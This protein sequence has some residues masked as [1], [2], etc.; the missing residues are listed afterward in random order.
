MQSVGSIFSTVS[1]FYYELNPATLSGAIDVVVVEQADGELSCSPFH[2]RFGKLS[3]LRPQEKVVEV[4]ING[5]VVDFPMKVGDAGEAFFVFETEQEVPE[6]FATSPLAGPSTDKVEEDIVYLDLAQGNNSTTHPPDDAALDTGYVSAHSGHGSEFEEDERADLSPEL[7]KNTHYASVVKFGGAK[8]QSRPQSTFNKAATPVHAFMEERVQRWSLTMSLPPSPVL[9]ARDIMENFQPIDSAGPF[10]DGRENT[11]HLLAPKLISSNMRGHRGSLAHPQDHMIMDMTGYKTED[12]AGETDLDSDASGEHEADTSPMTADTSSTSAHVSSDLDP[13]LPSRS[14]ARSPLRPK[15]NT[16]LGT[17]PNRRSS[18]MP[19]LKDLGEDNELS[20]NTPAI[21]RRFPSKNLSSM[22]LVKGDFRDESSS[23]SSVA[24]SPPPPEVSEQSPKSR[25][26][27]HHHHHKEHNEG[28]HPRRHSHK[29]SQQ[30]QVKKAP[31]RSNPAVNALSDTELEEAS[32][33]LFAANQVSFD[34][35]SKDPLKI[36][37]NKNL[38]CLINDRYFT[39]TVAGPYLSSLILFRK[40]L[41]DETLHQLS[42]KD[43]R[44]LSDR[45][46]IQDDPPTRFGALSRWLRGSQT[47]SHLSAMEQGQRQRPSSMNNALQ[48]AQPEAIEDLQAVKVEAISKDTALLQPEET[49]HESLVRELEPM[50]RSTSLPIDNGVA[51]SM[52]DEHA[53]KPP[54]THP[55]REINKRYAKTLRLTSEQLKSLSLKKGANTLTFSVTS[56]YQGKAVCSA[57][58]FLWDH[59]YQVVISDIDGTITKSDALGHIFTMA[60]KDWTHSGVA[61]LYTDIV[62]NGYHILYLT[63]RAIGQADYTRKYLKNVEQNNYQLPDGPVIMS[64]DRLMTAFHREVIMRKP[65]EFKMACLRDIRRLF[66]DRNPFYAGFGNRIT[67]ALSYRSVNVPSSRIFTIDSG[68]EVKLELLSSYKSSYLA[69]NDLVNEIFPGKRQAPEFNDW[70]FWRAPSLTS[71]GPL[72]T[73]ASIPT[74]ASSTPTAPNSYPSA[75][76]LRSPHQSQSGS[77]PP[78]PVSAPSGLQIADRTRRLS[79]SLM[80][81]GSLP[82]PSSA[83]ALRPFTDSPG[84]IVGMESS[85]KG[86][87]VDGHH[88][89]LGPLGSPSL[90]SNADGVDP[91]SVPAVKKK[92]SSFSVSPPQLA[93]RLSESVMPFLRRRTSKLEQEQENEQDQQQEQQEQEQERDLQFQ[94]SAVAGGDPLAYNR[95]Y[96]K[97]KVAAG[98][99]QE[100][101]ELGGEFEDQEGEG[102]EGY[103]GYYEDDDGDLEEEEEEEEEENQLEG[104]DD[105]DDDVEL[106]ID[107]PFL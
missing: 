79:L 36:L 2:V 94:G 59:D 50:T 80:R 37:N 27:H 92:V 38:V 102:A 47:S 95:E 87:V 62:N 67:D 43:P 15:G 7:D 85:E 21:L 19:N 53:G 61:K 90:E 98:Y 68:G 63:S 1:K 100:D 14:A 41:S 18:S 103:V 83:P 78:P 84:S 77:S 89:A 20:P 75:K 82:A 22:F 28:A 54:P 76:Q 81:Y 73:R 23:S 40:P 10:D 35:F 56:S 11:E 8:G 16:G 55:A 12:S 86:A 88:A 51:G 106:N 107:A 48:S 70:N 42:A 57:K 9:K 30:A 97:E 72:K 104:E 5:C 58:L 45:L 39:W 3:I 105:D 29:P 64:P 24:S 74:F 96:G 91:M 33:A 52:S 31:P 17:L 32:E 25:H 4:T 66:G 34:E 65:E 6:E 44:H 60:G 13:R 93:S 46:S 71:A 99:L 26:R 49:R 101:H 69:L